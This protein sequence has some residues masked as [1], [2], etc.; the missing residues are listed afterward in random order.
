MSCRQAGL[1]QRG[2]A[3]GGWNTSKINPGSKDIVQATINAFTWDTSPEYLQ[4][5]PRLGDQGASY[6]VLH[7]TVDV[8]VAHYKQEW[9]WDAVE[10]ETDPKRATLLLAGRKVKGTHFHV[11]K[12]EAKNTAYAMNKV[13]FGQ[14]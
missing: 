3:A 11:D 10:G 2:E 4:F 5:N 6:T 9:G 14:A 8:R 1:G 13:C 7:R 12:T